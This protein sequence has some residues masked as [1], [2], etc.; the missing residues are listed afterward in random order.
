MFVERDVITRLIEMVENG[1]VLKYDNMKL[2]IDL[3]SPDTNEINI[4]SG[5][6]AVIDL[7]DIRYRM[8]TC[9][10]SNKKVY[11]EWVNFATSYRFLNYEIEH[12]DLI[13]GYN[14]GIMFNRC[15]IDII[16]CLFED[17]DSYAVGAETDMGLLVNYFANNLRD[18]F[19]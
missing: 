1:L 13:D 3:I 16:T 9:T 6:E 19:L 2:E 10:D 15:V 12:G 5:W 7:D 14:N 4:G 11:I 18:E 8:N 17:V